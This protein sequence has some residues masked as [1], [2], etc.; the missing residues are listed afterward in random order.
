MIIRVLGALLFTVLLSTSAH[1]HG[2]EILLT[3]FLLL[4][5]VA[6]C[7]VIPAFLAKAWGDR[8]VIAGLVLLA[9]ALGMVA[10]KDVP[11]L[12]NMALHNILAVGL[13][14]LG[15]VAALYLNSVRGKRR[16]AGTRA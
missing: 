12:P 6:A 2:G 4:A 9:V 15:L 13:P 8:A 14:V 7:I 16:G 1:A 3:F 5:S 11:F 10:T